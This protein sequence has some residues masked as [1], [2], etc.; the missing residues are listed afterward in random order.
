MEYSKWFTYAGKYSQ[1]KW[2]NLSKEAKIL[3]QY[4]FETVDIAGVRAISVRQVNF[5]TG[6][7]EK[8]IELAI[9]ELDGSFVLF[10]DD[11][12]LVHVLDF[13]KIQ[14]NYPINPQNTAHKGVINRFKK[15]AYYFRSNLE[16]ISNYE[17][18]S[19]KQIITI[20][21]YLKDSFEPYI[22]KG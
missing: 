18:L 10:S 16:V 9:K 14:Q 1:E 12:S 3:Y 20:G 7:K 8:E 11:K 21:E 13:L 2:I 6:L 22:S 4:C 5:E 17:V 15:Y 19:G